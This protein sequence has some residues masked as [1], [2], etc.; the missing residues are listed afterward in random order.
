MYKAEQINFEVNKIEILNDYWDKANSVF[1]NDLLVD[2]ENKAFLIAKTAGKADFRWDVACKG[3]HQQMPYVDR[4][5]LC[6]CNYEI[7]VNELK[8]DEL[9]KFDIKKIDEEMIKVS[10]GCQVQ[11]YKI[12]LI[13]ELDHKNPKDSIKLLVWE[14]GNTQTSYLEYRFEDIKTEWMRKYK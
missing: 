2:K 3:I 7:E 10:Y 9:A 11:G 6:D 1:G 12:V 5:V 8:G 14:D 13:K 4:W